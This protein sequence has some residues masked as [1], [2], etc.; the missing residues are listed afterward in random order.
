MKITVDN[1]S[2]SFS[3]VHDGAGNPL[4]LPKNPIEGDKDMVYKMQEDQQNLQIKKVPLLEAATDSSKE[5]ERKRIFH[6]IARGRPQIVNDGEGVLSILA[7]VKGYNFGY[8]TRPDVAHFKLSEDDNI[9]GEK[10]PKFFDRVT[11]ILIDSATSGNSITLSG[12]SK[13][14]RGKLDLVYKDLK[15]VVLAEEYRTPG[16]LMHLDVQWTTML[17]KLQESSLERQ[18]KSDTKSEI[19]MPAG[20]QQTVAA[21]TSRLEFAGEGGKDK[22]RAFLLE[23]DNI[24]VKQANN[25]PI[26]TRSG[27]VDETDPGVTSEVQKKRS[28]LSSSAEGSSEVRGAGSS[29]NISTWSAEV[30][31]D[32]ANL[33]SNNNAL[34]SSLASSSNKRNKTKK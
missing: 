18:M 14:W 24:T 31:G 6:N 8:E 3:Q 22:F 7:P 13:E 10:Y 23:K 2:Y 5:E 32:E 19:T 1:I 11:K 20:V 29:L 16:A 4:L 9:T 30:S 17:E 34:S 28:V 25:F 15:S 21:A 26:L 33:S 27:S 12:T